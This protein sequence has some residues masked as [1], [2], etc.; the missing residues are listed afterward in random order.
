VA[1]H[2]EPDIL[3]VDEVLAV[4]D[5][6]FQRKCLDKMSDVGK[7][8]RTVLFI[9]HVMPSI[10]RL[11]QRTIVL[12]GGKL[13]Q[14]GSSSNVVSAYLKSVLS[15]SAKQE[16]VNPDNAPGDEV[17][18]LRSVAVKDEDGKVMRW[19][20]LAIPFFLKLYMM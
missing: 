16:W 8:G 5:A 15:T 12:D 17:V 9:S 13:I 7:D 6:A 10:I 14:D 3:V 20:I 19:L 1:A 4:G 2:L 11:C 18:R